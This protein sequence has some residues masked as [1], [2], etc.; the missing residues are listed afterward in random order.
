MIIIINIELIVEGIKINSLNYKD[1]KK[2]YNVYLIYYS[3]INMI[4]FNIIFEFTRE[5]YI[6]IYNNESKYYIFIIN[7]NAN[8]LLN[9]IIIII[10]IFKRLTLNIYYSIYIIVNKFIIF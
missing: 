2:N 9:K 7:N 1:F 4:K 5:E 10:N 3:F 8:N 6:I